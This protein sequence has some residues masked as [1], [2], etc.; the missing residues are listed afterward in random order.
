MTI[1][2]PSVKTRQ[3]SDIVFYL[4]IWIITSN[5]PFWVSV[6]YFPL[7]LSQSCLPASECLYFCSLKIFEI[8]SYSIMISLLND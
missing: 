5:L 1:N 7:A 2:G 8:H 6:S 3:D 4:N